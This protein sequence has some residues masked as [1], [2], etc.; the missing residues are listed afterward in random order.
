MNTATTTVKK[1]SPEPQNSCDAL[2][3]MFDGTC[4]LCRREIG[5]YQSLT[6]LQPVQWM[7]VSG[8]LTGLTPAEQAGFM[9]RFHV[10]QK[11]GQL[12]SGAAAFV[13]LW[14]TM[15]GWRWLGRF[16]R[17]PGVTATLEVMYNAFLRLRP[18]LQ[19]WVRALDVSH[20]P[21]DMVGDL[22]SDHAGETGAV[23]IYQGMLWASRDAQVREF[24]SRHMHT[25]QQHL[26]R[27]SVL[28]PPLRRSVLL[29]LW[30]VAGFVT[31]ALPALWGPRAVFGTV[32]AVETFVDQ[33]YQQQIDKLSGRDGYAPLMQLLV[34]CQQDE[35][36]HLEEA[37]SLQAAPAG[38]LLRLWCKTVGTGSKFAVWFARKI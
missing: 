18:R 29:P 12:L 13:A 31:G 26:E 21:S 19:R 34:D 10:R 3:V 32:A 33:H 17:L 36:A 37:S 38:L 1:I 5:V 6:P 23:A 11:D 8:D 9:A 22:R 30:R 25:E 7:D 27:V 28:L 16:A 2:T 35:L 15:P 24:A 20:L 14:L 4:P